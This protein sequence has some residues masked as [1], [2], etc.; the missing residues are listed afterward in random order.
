MS[1][2][3]QEEK[4]RMFVANEIGDICVYAIDNDI[5]PQDMLQA[6]S[7]YILAF[8]EAV[9]LVGRESGSDG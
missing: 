3:M 6:V 1:N 5:K 9:T 8:L 7:D 2:F 4:H